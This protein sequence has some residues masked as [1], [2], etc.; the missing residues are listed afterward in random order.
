[1][2]FIDYNDPE[3][4]TRRL[5]LAKDMIIDI[6]YGVIKDMHIE[7][8]KTYM[9]YGAGLMWDNLIVTYNGGSAIDSYQLLNPREHAEIC[10]FNSTSD[11]FEIAKSVA[12]RM[13]ERGW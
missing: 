12:Q 2:K 5:N 9:D 1:M 11:V 6:L 8:K 7:V 4:T 13:F 3:Q 10:K